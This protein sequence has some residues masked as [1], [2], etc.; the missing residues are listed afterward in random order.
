MV[1]V[2]WRPVVCSASS[3]A[4]VSLRHSDWPCREGGKEE[5]RD[6]EGL[7][8]LVHSTERKVTRVPVCRL[9]CNEAVCY[10]LGQKKLCLTVLARDD[11]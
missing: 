6:P 5:R 4:V 1:S 9:F 11:G 8:D 3:K 2:T 10:L 7:P